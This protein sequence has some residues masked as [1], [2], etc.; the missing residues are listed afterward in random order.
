MRADEIET[1]GTTTADQGRGFYKVELDN[2]SEV[3]ARL[4]RK[5]QLR[6]IRVLPE[7]RVTVAL[8]QYDLSRGRIMYRHIDGKGKQVQQKLGRGHR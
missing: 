8:S 6:H 1:L 5:M 7:D 3:L 4:C 2:G